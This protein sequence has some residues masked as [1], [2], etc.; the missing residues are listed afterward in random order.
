MWFWS[1][2]RPDAMPP[3]L[4]FVIGLL[5]DLLGYLPLGVR[6]V[7]LLAVHGIAVSMR[8]PLAA[9]GLRGDLAGFAWLPLTAAVADVAAGHA[10]ERSACCPPNAVLFQSV[11]AVAIY[12]VLAIPFSAAHRS[13]ANPDNV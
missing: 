3:P 5:V 10:A 9:R 2:C 6:R 13:V 7:T 11:L 8:R 4:V 1:L 12:P